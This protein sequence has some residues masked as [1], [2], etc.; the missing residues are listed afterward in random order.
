MVPTHME[1]IVFS[2]KLTAEKDQDTAYL[3]GDQGSVMF[4]SLVGFKEGGSGSDFISE[5]RS[6]LKNE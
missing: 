1:G 2:W 3:C 4:L 5:L 6:I